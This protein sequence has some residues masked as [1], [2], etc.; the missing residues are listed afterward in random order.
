MQYTNYQFMI[1][2]VFNRHHNFS[3]VEAVYI[4][5]FK[6]KLHTLIKIL[7][8]LYNALAIFYIYGGNLSS[9]VLNYTVSLFIEKLLDLLKLIDW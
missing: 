3:N 6:R 4:Q 9:V 5:N 7:C 1:L 2:H 8:D